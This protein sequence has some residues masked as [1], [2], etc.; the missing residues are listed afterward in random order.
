MVLKGKLPHARPGGDRPSHGHQGGDQA[1]NSPGWLRGT[2]A[3]MAVAGSVGLAAG[4]GTIAVHAAT[5]PTPSV[6]PDVGP[7]TSAS[8]STGASPSTTAPT[9]P[10]PGSGSGT[11][12]LPHRET[13]DRYM[14][15]RR[16]GL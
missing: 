1:M 7:S 2:L 13:T 16:Q 10:A 14:R 11:V 5:S 4:F 3:K 15:P 8:P 6:S 9:T 12:N